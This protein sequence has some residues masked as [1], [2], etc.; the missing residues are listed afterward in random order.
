MSKTVRME[1]KKK[2]FLVVGGLR[3]KKKR[4]VKLA[5]IQLTIWAIVN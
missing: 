5:P 2:V 1:R 3:S 4:R